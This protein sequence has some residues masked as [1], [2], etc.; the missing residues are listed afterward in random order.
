[1]HC[2][3][4]VWYKCKTSP[5]FVARQEVENGKSKIL[6]LLGRSLACSGNGG[7]SEL[8][9]ASDILGIGN[10]GMG[11][12]ALNCLQCFDTVGWAAG[13]ASGL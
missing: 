1:M 10:F 5:V 3:K 9:L 13:R 8:V 4:Q 11:E 7:R 6:I 12:L 2:C